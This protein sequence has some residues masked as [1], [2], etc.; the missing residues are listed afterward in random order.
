MGKRGWLKTIALYGVIVLISALI[1]MGIANQQV[2]CFMG[3]QSQLCSSSSVNLSKI[4]TTGVEASAVGA[5]YTKLAA[6]LANHSLRQA[7]EETTKRILEISGQESSGELHSENIQK[8]P[9]KDLHT[10][11]KLW[12]AHSGG[13]FGFSAQKQIYKKIYQESS[14]RPGVKP[15]QGSIEQYAF[16]RFA[17]RVGW[18]EKDDSL[19]Y[20]ELKF[21]RRGGKGHLP[22]TYVQLGVP[23]C[24][25]EV[26]LGTFCFLCR[27][28]SVNA[29][30]VSRGFL[31]RTEACN[32]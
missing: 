28:W 27:H 2:R 22:M 26:V 13:K 9:C 19:L 23:R 30:E 14:R 5:D 17:E 6:L 4:P 18:K 12:A 7:D 31:S 21:N 11:N 32:L 16:E 25:R 1:G 29:P 8:L 24:C 15:Y 3:W 10:I 20:K